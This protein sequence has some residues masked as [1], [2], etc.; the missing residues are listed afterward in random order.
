MRGCVICEKLAVLGTLPASE[1]VWGT[2]HWAVVHAFDTAL[3]GWLVLLSRAHALSYA[4]LSDDA[5]QELGLVQ[6]RLT[7]ALQTVLGA[8]KTYAVT[9]AE[10]GDYPHLHVHVIPRMLDQAPDLKGPN[11][12]K[13]LGVPADQAVSQERR[14]ELAQQLNDYLSSKEQQ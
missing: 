10:H 6:K 1:N 5:V 12:F 9:F 7:N 11:I 2:E 13:L 3:E 8:Q 14:T 4:D